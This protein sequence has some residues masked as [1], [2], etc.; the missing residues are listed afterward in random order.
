MAPDCHHAIV[1]GLSAA[2]ARYAAQ[3]DLLE[4]D[5]YEGEMADRELELSA[6]EFARL[7]AASSGG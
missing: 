7:S 4:R 6:A 2:H 3:Y 5:E 1:A